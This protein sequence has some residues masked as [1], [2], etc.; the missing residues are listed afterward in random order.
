MSSDLS[1]PLTSSPFSVSQEPDGFDI[2][3]AQD[4]LFMSHGEWMRR[5]TLTIGMRSPQLRRLD[6]AILKAEK[7]AGDI[8]FFDDE[9]DRFFHYGLPLEKARE[10]R[11]AMERDAYT[12]VREA[13]QLWAK[14]EGN[15]RGSRRSYDRAPQA[16]FHQL[17]VLQRKYPDLNPGSDKITT[18]GNELTASLFRNAEVK[19]RGADASNVYQSAEQAMSITSAISELGAVKTAFYR[20]IEPHFG[21]TLQNVAAVDPFFARELM[22]AVP[23][24]THQIK[25]LVK[26]L[27]GVGVAAS[28]VSA[29]SSLYDVHQTSQRRSKLVHV[30]RAMPKGD[31]LTALE[32]IKR[33]QT[34]FIRDQKIAAAANAG[35][36]GTQ[37][38]AIVAPGAHVVATLASAANSIAEAMNVL[39]ELGTQ[40]RESQQLRQYLRKPDAINRDIFAICPL[41]GAYY[42]LNVP[43][44]V[45]S[46]HLVPLDSPTF[47]GDTEYLRQSGAMKAVLECAESV[48]DVSIYILVKDG[49]PFRSRESMRTE[50]SIKLSFQHLRRRLFG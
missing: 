1:S 10:F 49:K 7:I 5:T 38:L 37:I 12:I 39:V 16:I 28:T 32:G 15:W 9:L 40:Y 23:R 6:E 18:A 8:A 2:I 43:F 4:G 25:A 3:P 33:W 42:V 27:P 50:V 29:L 19:V 13:F 34:Q 46:L 35:V 48:L 21:D 24:L 20:L 26:M 36:A 30:A 47:M 22:K 41:V 44:S 14:S 31:A 11:A 17:E 45:F